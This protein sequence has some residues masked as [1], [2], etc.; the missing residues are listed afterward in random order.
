MRGVP[1]R[2]RGQHLS[3]TYRLARTAIRKLCLFATGLIVL[4][5]KVLLIAYR[6]KDVNT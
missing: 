5:L 2:Y 1:A 3:I 6:W 4:T